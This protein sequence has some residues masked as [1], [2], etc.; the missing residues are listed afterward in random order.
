MYPIDAHVS[1]EQKTNNAKEE[2][3]PSWNDIFSSFF[4]RLQTNLLFQFCVNLPLMLSYSLLYPL[5][6]QKKSATVGKLIQNIDVTPSW[7]SFLAWFC[8]WISDTGMLSE[9]I[10][11]VKKITRK[12]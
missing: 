4:L 2:G 10:F 5:T 7:I 1:E 8:C 6:S 3:R 12:L 11:N 9:N